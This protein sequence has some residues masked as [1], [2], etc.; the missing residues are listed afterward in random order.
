MLRQVE[1]EYGGKCDAFVCDVRAEQTGTKRFLESCGYIEVMAI[2]LY[3]NNSLD[4]V[5]IKALDKAKQ[6]AII[7]LAK[8]IIH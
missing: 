3:D 8:K 6:P 2:P 7:G 5:M 1:V 4:V